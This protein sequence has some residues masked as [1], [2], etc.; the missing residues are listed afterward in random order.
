MVHVMI[1]SGVVTVQLQEGTTTTTTG[2]EEIQQFEDAAVGETASGEVANPILPTGNELI[3]GAACFLL[4]WALMKF[5]LLKPVVATMEER[6]DKSREDLDAADVAKAEAATAL[7]EYESS[8]AGAR[9]EASR[10]VDDARAQAEAARA[11]VIAE[12]EADAA[13]VRGEAAAEVEAAKVAALTQM[14]PDLT[15]VAVQAAQS[16]VGRP[17]NAAEQQAVVEEYLDRAGSQ[18]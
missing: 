10:I 14:R 5:W 7:A 18:N 12:A 3:W 17:L 15:Q 8:L 13:R 1:N 2:T 9:A 16:V 11:D 6:A 4:L